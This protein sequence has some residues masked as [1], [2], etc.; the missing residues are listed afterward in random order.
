M[1]L[2][3]T[4]HNLGKRFNRHW[5]FRQ[6]NYQF[7]SGKSYAITGAN[8]SGKST[9]LQIIAGAMQQSEGQIEMRFEKERIEKINSSTP[10]IPVEKHYQHISL[11]APYMELIEELTLQEFLDFHFRFKPVLPAYTIASIIDYIQL[12]DATHKQIRLFSSGMKQRVMLAQA[13]F[14]NTPLILLDEPTTNLDT[15]GIDLYNR[16]VNEFCKD[17]LLIIC[18]NDE[19]EI[20]FCLER[21]NIADYIK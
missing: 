10:I 21:L 5:I 20:S 1:A 13:I 9:L 7:C 3:L 8:G 15:K 11:A 2:H 16:L 6:I 14:S 17:R 12:K 19:H 18:S 4:L